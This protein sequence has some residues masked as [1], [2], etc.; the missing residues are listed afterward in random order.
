MM[1]VPS[2]RC[3]VCHDILYGRPEMDY[4]LTQRKCSCGGIECL[5]DKYF[6]DTSSI[7]ATELLS[8]ILQIENFKELNQMSGYISAK[9]LKS[10]L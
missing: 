6:R 2:A 9:E 7:E 4:P 8:L 5:S 10:R 3:S 1:S